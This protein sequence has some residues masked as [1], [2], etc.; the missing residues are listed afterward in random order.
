[1]REQLSVRSR[2]NTFAC[3]HFTVTL[4]RPHTCRFPL[5]SLKLCFF[6]IRFEII[7]NAALDHMLAR[8]AYQS[9]N[10]IVYLYKVIVGLFRKN[11][12]KA[13]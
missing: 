10:Q 11:I 12:S 1:M 2:R 9:N 3:L 8:I 5:K 4:F 13:R 6:E 7:A